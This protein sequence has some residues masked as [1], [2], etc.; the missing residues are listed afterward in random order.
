MNRKLL[1]EIFTEVK[2]IDLKEC[3]RIYF[4]PAIF[5]FKALK[6]LFFKIY[7]FFFYKLKISV[8]IKNFR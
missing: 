4:A 7:K 6:F 1:N 2:K 5:I 3:V 8:R